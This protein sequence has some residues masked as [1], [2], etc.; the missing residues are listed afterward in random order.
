MV[1]LD[2]S[3]QIADEARKLLNKKFKPF[4]TPQDLIVDLMEETGELAKA[5]SDKEIRK[6]D[7]RG[8]DV[9]TE[10]VDIYMNLLWIANHYN[11]EFEKEFIN[12]VNKWNKRYKFNIKI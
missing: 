2:Q 7:L 10:L 5:I 11:I 12:T 1:T 9:S 4:K 8:D 3:Q 6:Q